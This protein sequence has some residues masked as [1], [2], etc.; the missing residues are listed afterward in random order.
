[1]KRFVLTENERINIKKMYK[2]DEAQVPNEMKNPTSNVG[3]YFF[4]IGLDSTVEDPLKMYFKRDGNRFSVWMDEIDPSTNAINTV[5]TGYNLPFTNELGFM[6]KD[7]K[8]DFEQF[9]SATRGSHSLAM[10]LSQSGQYNDNV[11]LFHDTVKDMPSLGT[12]TVKP[13]DVQML[14]DMQSKGKISQPTSRVEIKYNEFIK[15]TNK[16]GLLVMV[17][18]TSDAIKSV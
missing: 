10:K 16:E 7:N 4:T 9:N 17:Q 14:Q 12:I 5:A 13:F 8:I 15:H 3:E 18:K 6:L 2:V 1:M 11:V